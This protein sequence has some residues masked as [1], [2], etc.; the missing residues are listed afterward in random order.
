MTPRRIIAVAGL[1]ILGVGACSSDDTGPV[2]SETPG[3]T[4][5]PHDTASSASTPSTT[6]TTDSEPTDEELAACV[7]E[8]EAY[9]EEWRAALGDKDFSNDPASEVFPALREVIINPPSSEACSR[10]ESPLSHRVLLEAFE[11]EAPGYA[12]LFKRVEEVGSADPG[13][14]EVASRL[15]ELAEG[16]DHIDERPIPDVFEAG[17]LQSAGELGDCT[18][19]DELQQLINDGF[20]VSETLGTLGGTS[21]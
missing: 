20:F 8:I 6:V 19:S 2:A 1:A 4:V 21:A 11:D 17:L 12:E 7:T 10:F 18:P 14:D 16:V 15:A 3:T 13:C 5:A 9:G